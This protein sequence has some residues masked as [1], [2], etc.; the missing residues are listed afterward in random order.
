MFAHALIA[1]ILCLVLLPG[2]G[3]D[4]SSPEAKKAKHQERAKAYV[5]KGQYQEALIEYQNAAQADPKDANLYYQMALLHLK[6]GQASHLQA[7]FAE[8]TRSVQL[9]KHNQDAQLK[10]GELYL[11]GNEPARAREQADIV[12]VS[13]PQSQEGLVLKGRSLVN[14]KRHQ[15]AI[16]ELKKAIE[17]NPKNIHVYVEL[18]RAYFA[19][20]DPSSAEATL[21]EALKI[22][23]NSKEILPALGDFY[24]STGKPDQAETI[25]KQVLEIAPENEDTYLRLA[26]LYQRYNKPA[27]AE[28]SLQKL[29]ALKPQ[30]EKP[31][32]YLG[33]FFRWVGEP[34]K[35]LASYRRATQVNPSSIAARDMLISQYLDMGNTS[36]AETK[37]KA[38]LEK[39]NRD[40]SGRFFEGR[41]RLAKGNADDAISLFQ[42]VIKDEP[43]SSLA[44]H[45]LGI[46]FLQKRQIG[47]ARAALVEAVKLNPNDGNSRT[48]LARLYLAEGSADL[49]IEQAQAA[50]QINPRNVQ[51]AI[52]SG[53]AYLVKR[54]FAKSRQLFEIVSQALPNDPIGPYRLGLIAR[55]EKNDAKALAYF[56]EALVRKPAAIEPIMQ[57]AMVKV[58]QGKP[59]EA[60][61][62]VTKQLEASPNNPQ[63]YI[64]LGQLWFEAKDPAE[65]ETAFKKAIELD[66]ASLSAYMGLGQIYQQAGKTDQAIKEYEAVLAKDPNE[67]RANMLLGLIHEGRREYDKAQNRYETILKLNPKFAPA[68]NNLAWIMA[69]QGGNLDVALSYAQ[70]AR[71]QQPDNPNIAD[72]LGWIY[73]KKNAYL[74]ATNLLKE[75]AEK[76]TAEPVVQYHYG[77]AL[78]KNGDKPGAKKALQT[79]LK[80]NPSFPGADD[81]RKAL[82]AL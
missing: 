49:A 13:A 3:C 72:T 68:G 66:H 46:A 50:I 6:L 31:H 57:I 30:D 32:I 9:D 21:K 77:M 67:V 40:L 7:A 75:A 76:L 26:A 29:A 81:A 80:L 82:Q 65:A 39:N 35:A 16:A 55:A 61:E 48:A 59:K 71:E 4:S 74:L 78:Q 44:H 64:L 27:E 70:T 28:A 79:A 47:Q 37:V 33:D 73:Y 24:V 54:D 8:L 20:N 36:E 58:A 5:E 41:I 22:E 56:E 11:L 10:L 60:R 1:F 52:A 62:R 25:Y 43:K 23:P 2:I 34:D 45:F 19:A 42:G 63:L 18:A 14:E 15:E 51:A 38:I 69:E 53:D 17:L 12:L